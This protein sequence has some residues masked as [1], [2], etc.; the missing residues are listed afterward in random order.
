MLQGI[1]SLGPK[2][3]FLVNIYGLA[4]FFVLVLFHICPL[5]VRG[6]YGLSDL[7]VVPLSISISIIS[8]E[9]N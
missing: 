9:S 3:E 1:K 2:V 8:I 6:W 5:K 7:S 4:L